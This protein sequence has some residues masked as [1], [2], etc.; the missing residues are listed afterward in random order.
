MKIARVDLHS[1]VLFALQL[2]EEKINAAAS[3]MQL[4]A[5][6]VVQFQ[7]ELTTAV[8]AK[9]NEGKKGKDK[10]AP[11]EG[12]VDISLVS[13]AMCLSLPPEFRKKAVG[14]FFAMSAVCQRRGCVWDIWDKG[15]VE[16]VAQIGEACQAFDE[17]PA[18]TIAAAE[19]ECPPAAATTTTTALAQ[20]MTPAIHAVVELQCDEKW[21]LGK[22]NDYLTAQQVKPKEAQ[23]MVKT[24]ESTL[25][26]YFG[27]L[28]PVGGDVPLQTH[29][30]VKAF[31]GS[32]PD[33]AVVRPVLSSTLG[34]VVTMDETAERTRAAVEGLLGKAIGWLPPRSLSGPSDVAPASSSAGAEAGE[35]LHDGGCEEAKQT[36]QQVEEPE[37]AKDIDPVVRE[38]LQANVDKVSLFFLVCSVR[39]VV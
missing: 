14:L 24:M 37:G 17:V 21:L 7:K 28:Q 8:E 39:H 12:K 32:A 11:S 26:A 10:A 15:C 35:A 36:S 34:S 25:P 9:L 16:E 18:P 19:G 29:S 31:L 30:K 23:A 5:A 20:A 38:K 27:Q 1:A 4:R 22:Y 6:S 13:E 33:V 2:S 3:R